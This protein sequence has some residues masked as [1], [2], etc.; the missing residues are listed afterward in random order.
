MFRYLA[1][2]F[3]AA[4]AVDWPTWLLDR[5]GVALVGVGLLALALPPR[6]RRIRRP[7]MPRV[8]ARTVELDEEP[9]AAVPALAARI[10]EYLADTRG[11][12]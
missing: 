2:A 3:L 10:G 6:P 5:A 7:A 9:D 4:A 11:A 1:F 12:V 8:P